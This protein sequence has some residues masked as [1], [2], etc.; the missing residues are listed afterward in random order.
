M[1]PKSSR[2]GLVVITGV[3]RPSQTDAREPAIPRVLGS[4]E[5]LSLRV[6]SDGVPLLPAKVDGFAKVDGL[7]KVDEFVPQNQLVDLR[8][9]PVPISASSPPPPGPPERKGLPGLPGRKLHW[10]VP[11]TLNPQPSTLN[12]QPSTLNP[13]PSNL[14]PQPSTLKPQPSTLKPQ[15]ST[16]NP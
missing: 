3:E 4:G 16:L 10:E 2:G 6:P 11:S 5:A 1:A 12:P 14:K 7:I 8:S 13:Q 15:P 9:V